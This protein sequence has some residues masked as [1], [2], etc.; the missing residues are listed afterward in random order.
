MLNGAILSYKP[1]ESDTR[2]QNQIK[3]LKELNMQVNILYLPKSTIPILFLFKKIKETKLFLFKK[4]KETKLFLFKKI[5]EKGLFLFKKINKQEIKI[6][7]Y[8]LKIIFT[9]LIKI[10]LIIFYI[11]KII[12][13][14]LI[15]IIFFNNPVKLI[16]KFI[17]IFYSLKKK[18][19][20]EDLNIIIANDLYTLPFGIYLKI[21]HNCK[22]IYD[23]HEY[24][25]D[26][27][28]KK[29]FISTVFLYL[30]EEATIPF[31]DY[32][33]TVSYSIKQYYKKRFNKK[34]FLILNSPL[35][36]N[37][38]VFNKPIKRS[39]KLK[40]FIMIGNKSYGRNIIEIIEIFKKTDLELTFMGNLNSKFNKEEKFL[41][42]IK[43]FKNIH[44]K[45]GVK[46]E[47]IGD[48]LQD[49]D[50]SLFLYDL[51]YKNYDYALPNKFILSLVMG[52]TIISF[53]TTE[54]KLFE[55]RHSTQLNLINN[56][57]DINNLKALN[58]PKLN[59]SEINFY[60]SKRQASVLKKIV[61]NLCISKYNNH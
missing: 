24:E 36:E 1:I 8:A 25:L 15:K 45:T 19:T 56:L 44:Y 54:L 32:I 49:F 33:T 41:D 7:F 40:K 9:F 46:P 3:T 59:T 22:L 57:N 60:S 23:M 31:A 12:F 52:K 26:R 6:I 51:S 2:V 18:D 5:K 30:I 53:V 21:K 50:A 17:Y 39:N 61:K 58:K 42:K 29:N 55:I 28:P 4:I 16:L 38:A 35:T 14:F 20:L 43:D 10:I 34:I 48:I 11:L 27:V 37:F 13:T 47:M